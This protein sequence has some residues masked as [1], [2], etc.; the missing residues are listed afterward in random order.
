MKLKELSYYLSYGF[1]ALV[2]RKRMPI[3]AGMPLTDVCNLKCMHCVVANT[4]R[5]HYSF[6]RLKEIM[7]EFYSRGARILYMQGGEI[8][9]WSD[10]ARTVNDVITEARKMGFFKVA[11]VTNGTFPITLDSDAIWVSMDGTEQFHDSVRG[12]GVFDSVINNVRNSTHPN[13]SANLTVN[14]KNI[15]C[16]AD[17]IKFISG[18]KRFRGV[19]VNFHTPY[20]GVEGLALDM[21]QRRKV[22]DKVMELKK[23][24]YKVLNTWRGLNG[25]YTGK[26]NRPVYMINLMEKD[27]IYECCWGREEKG[28]CEKCGY[29][30]IPEL[31][32]IQSLD[33]MAMIGAFGLFG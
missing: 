14:T 18:E 22:L 5:G 31:S 9:T 21:E 20:P 23:K 1:K 17:L 15:S 24:G 32:A 25:L 19:S 2:L 8:M 13:I 12:K 6:D 33:P 4:G 26:Y 3:V 10:G 16:V 11:T 27:R 7:S 29:G 30:I 28:V